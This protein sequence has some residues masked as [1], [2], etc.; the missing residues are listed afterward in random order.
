MKKFL[1]LMLAA[2]MIFGACIPAFAQ[3]GNKTEAAL[4]PAGGYPVIVVRGMDFTG[5]YI[6]YGTEK[7]HNC[8]GDIDI[9]GILKAV[10]SALKPL[11]DVI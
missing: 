10:G 6:D 11:I 4:Q 1:S 5:L 7:Q 8:M 2:V 9:G 3:E